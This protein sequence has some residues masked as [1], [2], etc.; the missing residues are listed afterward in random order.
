MK[1]PIKHF[2]PDTVRLIAV[3]FGIGLLV[4]GY[5]LKKAN[6]CNRAFRLW[7]Y[8][9]K[10]VNINMDKFYEDAKKWVYDPQYIP[11]DFE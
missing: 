3:V 10:G 7:F 6:T 4:M 5:Q 2:S 11:E 8:Y 9:H 1:A